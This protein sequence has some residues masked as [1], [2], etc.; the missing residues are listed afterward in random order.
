MDGGGGKFVLANAFYFRRATYSRKL[1]ER[2]VS[3]LCQPFSSCFF[4]FFFSFMS[5]SRSFF[6]DTRCSLSLS[7]S[8]VVR[9]R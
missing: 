2:V 3:F 7:R 5:V 6:R 1:N 4:P 8:P 9:A